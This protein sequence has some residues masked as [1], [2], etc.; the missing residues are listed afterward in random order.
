MTR[1]RTRF[2]R[3]ATAIARRALGTAA[4]LWLALRAPTA[5][6][7]PSYDD[8]AGHGCVT[9]HNGFQGGNGPLHFQHRTLLGI[10]T[11]NL[12]HPAGGGSTPVLTYTSGPGGGFGCAGCHGQDYGETSP[13][14]G[15]PKATAYGLRE[16]HVRKGVGACGSAG[17][18]NPGSLG[19]ADPFPTPLGENVAPPYYDPIFSSLMNS[20]SSAEEDLP[21]DA[22]PVGLDNDGD[23]LV[24]AADPD[25]AS[26]S[27]TT[28][29]TTTS[30][31]TTTTLFGCGSAPAA[32]CVVS[33][34]GVL[35]VNEKTA[36]KQTVKLSLSKLQTAIA[37]SEFGDPVTGTTRYQVC[38][39]DG[40]NELTG[41]Y[42]VARAG[43]L[44]GR[45]SC[46]A[47]M[48]DKGYQYTDKRTAA[49]GILKI[50]LSGGDVGKG[51]VM[52][53]G[54]NTASTLPIGVAAALRDQPGAT[55]QVL[56]SD[57]ACFGTSFTKVKKADGRTFSAV[58]P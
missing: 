40:A 33:G 46:W 17:C 21:F 51:R 39:Y 49:D 18:H 43:D 23:G 27:S 15:E 6:A 26:A 8:G 56:T 35:V 34:K 13:T 5:L 50:K 12:C 44:C 19:H 57:A 38:I 45:L 31:T 16:S 9:C 36:G 22:D 30:T 52:L 25:C 11:C 28:T 2:G 47:T 42:T 58:G 7:Y 54:K 29:T 14:S 24:D 37:P 32:G 20:C 4:L 3:P 1:P 41:T 10:T 53:V 48:S 55:V